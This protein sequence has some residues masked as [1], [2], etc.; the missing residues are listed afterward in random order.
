MSSI[1]SPTRASERATPLCSRVNEKIQ[2]IPSY[3]HERVQSLSEARAVAL[4][5]TFVFGYYVRLV[6]YMKVAVAKVEDLLA[7]SSAGIV[8]MK[9][10]LKDLKS[11]LYDYGMESSSNAAEFSKDLYAEATPSA[12]VSFMEQYVRASWHCVVGCADAAKK[13]CSSFLIA[14]CSVADFSKDLCA[15]TKPS[16]ILSFMEQFVRDS[17]YCVVGCADSV[18][19]KC[20]SFLIADKTIEQEVMGTQ[21][22]SKAAQVACDKDHVKGE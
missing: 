10:Q 17:W 15:E 13:K 4:T 7:V 11:Q 12:I 6:I 21:E 19:T 8:N 3:L 2:T 16:D 18:K 9:D 5:R 1:D 14:D 22:V 20:S